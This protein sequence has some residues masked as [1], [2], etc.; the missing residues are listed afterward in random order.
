MTLSTLSVVELLLS[1]HSGACLRV[2]MQIP[3]SGRVPGADLVGAIA[4]R[5]EDISCDDHH[6][7]GPLRTHPV[8]ERWRLCCGSEH[9]RLLRKLLFG[10]GRQGCRNPPAL[11]AF[12]HVVV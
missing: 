8:V 7:Q 2:C 4:A 1:I 3:L 10:R 11:P 6:G 5:L 9:L 12:A